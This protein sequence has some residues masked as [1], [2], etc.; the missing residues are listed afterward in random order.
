MGV[1]ET[2]RG[3]QGKKMGPLREDHELTLQAAQ[4]PTAVTKKK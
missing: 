2:S 3:G 1:T 4:K